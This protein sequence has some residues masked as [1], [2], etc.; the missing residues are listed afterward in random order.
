MTETGVEE[1][2]RLYSSWPTQLLRGYKAGLG[3]GD[4]GPGRTIVFCG[5]GG[6][7]VTGDIV[8][9][10]IEEYGARAKVC[11]SHK[12]PAWLGPEDI[13][14]GI[15]YSGN[16][17]ETI[18]CVKESLG[19]GARVAVVT[20]GGRLARLAVEEGLPLAEVA[21]GFYPRTA[22]AEMVGAA[23]G[24]LSNAYKL[25]E[26]MVMEAASRLKS[27]HRARARSIAER[28]A[29]ASMVG[30]VACGPLGPAARRIR[31]EL[32]ENSKIVAREEVYPESGHNDIVSWQASTIEKP[33]FLM[34]YWTR[35]TWCT[36][37]LSGLEPLYR[38]LGP[39]AVTILDSPS[40]LSAL[41]EASL[42]GGL[43]SVYLAGLRGVDPRDTSLI[44]RYKESLERLEGSD[45]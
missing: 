31:S 26:A 2:E 19:R 43:A 20:S 15:S 8:G 36:K 34:I 27:F 33:G 37:L 42:A 29:G 44:S 21:S 18:K 4:V 10:V 1:M 16:T 9:A 24:L 14:V 25:D 39:L 41:L 28:L 40:L 35:D 11:K 30:V 12:P 38:Q 22:M 7:G 45:G 6:S 17:I 32:A 13:V 5:M 23:L 3:T